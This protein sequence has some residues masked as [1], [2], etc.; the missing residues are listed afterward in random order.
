MTSVSRRWRRLFFSHPPLWRSFELR[1]PGAELSP[2]QR[3]EWAAAKHRLL[4]RVGP[5]VRTFDAYG[6]DPLQLGGSTRLQLPDFVHCLGPE[7]LESVTYTP[8][9]PLIESML[10]ALLRFP[11]L[12]SLSMKSMQHLPPNATWVLHQLGALVELASTV[13]SLPADALQALPSGLTYLHLHTLYE[14]L[15]DCRQLERLTR[16]RSLFLCEWAA[17]PM[18]M[19]LPSAAAFPDRIQASFGSPRLQVSPYDRQNSGLPYPE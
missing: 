11:R 4:Q 6:V 12:R 8:T 7:A 10:A 15:P 5:L 1:C 9:G 19:L 17:S 18:G 2:A 14:P 13:G 3:A 16:L